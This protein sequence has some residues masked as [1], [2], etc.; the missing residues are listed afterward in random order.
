M[1][2]A[3]CYPFP[4]WLDGIGRQNRDFVADPDPRDDM[5]ARVPW[6]V[7]HG[8]EFEFRALIFPHTHRGSLP[9]QLS[10]AF[11][12]C[13]T[14]ASPDPLRIRQVKNPI[15][16]HPLPSPP[17]FP[18]V[19][20]HSDT[21]RLVSTRVH[22]HTHTHTQVPHKGEREKRGYTMSAAHQIILPIYDHTDTLLPGAAAA[23]AAAASVTSSAAGSGGGGEEA[24]RTRRGSNASITSDLSTGSEKSVSVSATGKEMD[25]LPIYED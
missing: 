1:C 15:P 4:V 8:S 6:R 12:R 25:L 5:G 20:P 2:R 7:H 11:P 18:I 14:Q 3:T 22:A 10:P 23:A 13:S 17:S 9:S 24:D 21:N 19:V 16:P